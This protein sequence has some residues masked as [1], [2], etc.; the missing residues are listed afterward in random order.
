MYLP[1]DMVV[2]V[3]AAVAL[4]ALV[5]I[6]NASNISYVVSTVSSSRGVVLCVFVLLL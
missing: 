3:P 1:C 4:S 6:I 2:C 5:T